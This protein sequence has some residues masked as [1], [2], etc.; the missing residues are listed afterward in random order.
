MWQLASI[1]VFWSVLKLLDFLV[2][3]LQIYVLVNAQETHGEIKL[4]GEHALINVQIFLV[5][6]GMLKMIKKFVLLSVKMELG[7]GQTKN[8]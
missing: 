1:S 5:Y 2:K 6:Y 4:E 7:E 8:V 3:M